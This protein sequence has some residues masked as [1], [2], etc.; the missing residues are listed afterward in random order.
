MVS[1]SEDNFWFSGLEKKGVDLA[2]ET[3]TLSW[4]VERGIQIEC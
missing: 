3:L 1:I 4:N 2:N